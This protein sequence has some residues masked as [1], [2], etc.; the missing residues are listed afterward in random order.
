[1]NP[2]LHQ[3]I[4]GLAAHVAE[5]LGDRPFMIM[6]SSDHGLQYDPSLA[7]FWS[8]LGGWRLF[9]TMRNSQHYT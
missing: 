4:R 3:N 7:G 2:L 8:K 5:Q 1:M 9:L 6:T